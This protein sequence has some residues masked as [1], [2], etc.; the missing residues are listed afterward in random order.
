MKID[1]SKFKNF[2]FEL[3]D[4]T[5]VDEVPKDYS[6]YVSYHHCFPCQL[7]EKVDS[8]NY[9]PIHW[10]EKV[11]WRMFPRLRNRWNVTKGRKFRRSLNLIPHSMEWAM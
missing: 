1:L 5:K 7:T 6:G 10:Y 8:Y 9:H 4:G 11:L 2:W 3:E